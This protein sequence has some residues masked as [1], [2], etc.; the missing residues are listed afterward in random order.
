MKGWHSGRFYDPFDSM[1]EGELRQ[2]RIDAIYSHKWAT[3][4]RDEAEAAGERN[5]VLN[6]TQERIRLAGIG[7]EIKRRLTA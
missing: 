5:R 4:A 6:L 2:M 1:G 3:Q 7:N